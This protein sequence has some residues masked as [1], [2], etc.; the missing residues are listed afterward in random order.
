VQHPFLGIA[1]L[2]SISA[3]EAGRG[4][5]GAGVLVTSV[6]P[7]TPASQ[8]GVQSGDILVAIDGVNIDNGQTL[9]G[10]IQAK[11]VGQS[12]ALTIKR[13]SSSMTLHATLEERPSNT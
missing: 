4:F 8:A 12:I 10:L 3:I 5:N 7:N 1:Y 6:S 13:G 11:S 9:G 2:D